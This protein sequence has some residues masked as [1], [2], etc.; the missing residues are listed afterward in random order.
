MTQPINDITKGA[1]VIQNGPL[2][3]EMEKFLVLWTK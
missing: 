2:C 1:R 3:M